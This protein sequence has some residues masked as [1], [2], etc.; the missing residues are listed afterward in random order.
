MEFIDKDLTKEESGASFELLFKE[1]DSDS[2][3]LNPKNSACTIPL[4]STVLSTIKEF[5]KHTK[6]TE[7][8]IA[9]DLSESSRVKFF[10]KLTKKISD[11]SAYGLHLVDTK[12]KGK[13]KNYY[14]VNKQF[15]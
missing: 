8:L 6:I 11:E 15:V 3:E 2:Y 10:D 7:L 9:A 12:S 1:K 4:F 5:Q 13:F 14:L